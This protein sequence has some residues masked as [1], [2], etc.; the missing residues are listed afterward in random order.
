VEFEKNLFAE[1]KRIDLPVNHHVVPLSL[2][3]IK[4]L[5][6][7]RD[8]SSGTTDGQV[9]GT[10]HQLLQEKF[11]SL[12]KSLGCENGKN[13]SQLDNRRA[14]TAAEELKMILGELKW[15]AETVKQEE[16]TES[17]NGVKWWECISAMAEKAMAAIRGDMALLRMYVYFALRNNSLI[18]CKWQR[19]C[20]D[21]IGHTSTPLEWPSLSIPQL[22]IAQLS[23][24]L[25]STGISYV[26]AVY[27][28]CTRIY[29]LFSSRR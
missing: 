17:G 19:S 22:S 28:F 3:H 23:T 9:A 24:P 12:L 13:W 6:G 1:D 8:D 4:V 5:N 25:T 26:T 15:I 7:E 11:R 18:P 20:R 21:S 29:R 2:H 27:H 16:E 14:E 10:L